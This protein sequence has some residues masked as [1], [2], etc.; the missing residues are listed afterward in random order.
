MCG[1]FF[2]QNAKR[3]RTSAKRILRTPSPR[4]SNTL[5]M[6]THTNLQLPSHSRAPGRHTH[7]GLASS[8]FLFHGY[9]T[10]GTQATRTTGTSMSAGTPGRIRP[11]AVLYCEF[12]IHAGP[13][14][15][16]Q[17]PPASIPGS[18]F[19]TFSNYVIVKPGLTRKVTAFTVSLPV[20]SSSA[21]RSPSGVPTSTTAAAN[22]T[23]PDVQEEEEERG[24]YSPSS[25]QA[26]KTS[27][28][29]EQRNNEESQQRLRSEAHTRELCV[30]GF[31]MTNE[32]RKYPRNG[33]S[34]NLCLCF[35]CSST[36]PT[37]LRY[38]RL[39]RKAGLYL[40]ELEVDNHCSLFVVPRLCVVS[41]LVSS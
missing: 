17:H 35:E 9:P 32:N 14:I 18:V 15:I 29:A 6:H 27:V 40:L 22:P 33:F 39:I 21:A 4:G 5:R 16:Y 41:L 12:D 11:S 23:T 19:E 37:L 26:P 20:A 25:P 34:F 28:P 30:L 36:E 24:E 31:P 38:H 1:V 7:V 13:R 8:P 3:T 10:T 2:E